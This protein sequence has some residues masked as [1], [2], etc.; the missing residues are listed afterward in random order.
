M[1]YRKLLIASGTLTVILFIALAFFTVFRVY[2]VSVKYSVYSDEDYSTAEEVVSSYK[3]KNL[4]FL[5]AQEIA[6]EIV[7]KTNLKVLSVKKVYPFTIEVELF[8]S[9]ERFAIANENGG[10]Y[11]LD[12]DYVVLKTRDTLVNPADGLSDV[13]LEFKTELKPSITLKSSLIY[14]NEELFESLKTVASCFD[15]PRDRVYSI[16][17]I[18]TAEKGNYRIEVI[19]RSGVVMQIRKATALTREK[20]LA[21]ISKYES[22]KDN[23]LLSGT[24]ECYEMDN[25]EVVS[26]YTK[27]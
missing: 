5:D 18:E 17:V 16:S 25:G 9:E 1:K 27:R 8:S 7:E 3:G 22:L 2:D 14:E 20:T 11:V 4:V 24:I 26:V 12:V 15:S 10:Y 21:G 19:M 13:L 23:D 6:D